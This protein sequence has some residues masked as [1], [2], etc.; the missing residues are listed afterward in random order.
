MNESSHGR[1]Q[2]QSSVPSLSS[3]QVIQ[4]LRNALNDRAQGNTSSSGGSKTSVSSASEANGGSKSKSMR[5]TMNARRPGGSSLVKQNKPQ[6]ASA[7]SSQEVSTKTRSTVT[8]QSSSQNCS[9]SNPSTVNH[10]SCTTSPQTTAP[11]RGASDAKNVDRIHKGTTSAAAPT[12]NSTMS[13]VQ[14]S[15]VS[16]TS[17]VEQTV[18]SAVSSPQAKR[19]KTDTNVTQRGIDSM[20]GVHASARSSSSENEETT[21]LVLERLKSSA[22]DADLLDF[23]HQTSDRIQSLR[24]YERVGIGAFP[25]LQAQTD[26]YLNLL[27][28]RKEYCRRVIGVYP[29]RVPGSRKRLETLISEFQEEE[30]ATAR[31]LKEWQ[32]LLDSM[33][34][35][36]PTDNNT[37]QNE[38]S[39]TVR[40]TETPSGKHIASL[41]TNTLEYPRISDV[42]RLGHPLIYDYY[43]QLKQTNQDSSP[44]DSLLLEKELRR[45]SSRDTFCICRRPPTDE[46]I[47]CCNPR[48][49]RGAWFHRECLQHDTDS[50]MSPPGT[51]WYC[52]TCRSLFQRQKTQSATSA[53]SVAANAA[54]IQARQS[55]T[56]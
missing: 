18:G 9:D 31:K 38:S 50:C 8:K 39:P 2:Y 15:Y 43:A 44:E 52:P 32:E 56:S 29:Q 16:Q 11:V 12:E 23:Y 42:E 24:S 10:H 40:P 41:K 25:Q 28:S 22:I 51:F 21:E 14:S 6:D 55:S 34:K 20:N 17:N 30:F 7:T 5:S 53:L 45:T 49:S 35:L 19:R 47:L 27:R 33:D 36:A 46:M 54:G 3:S 37:E 13:S 26:S 1:R 4:R 48:C